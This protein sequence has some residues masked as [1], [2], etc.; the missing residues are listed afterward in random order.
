MGENMYMIVVLQI[1]VTLNI[2]TGV[3]FDHTVLTDVG[4]VVQN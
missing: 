3:G 2:W 4:P 1:V